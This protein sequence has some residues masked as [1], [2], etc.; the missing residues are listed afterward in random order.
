MAKKGFF[1][2]ITA[3]IIALMSRTGLADLTTALVAYYPFS[4]N[5]ND[6]SGNG[7]HGN[8]NG[9]TLTF[10]RFGNPNSAYSF[11]G[12]D[13]I[14][15][16]DSPQFTLGS[17]PFTLASWAKLSSFGADGG[18]YLMGHS[19]GPGQTDK[20]IF[21]L[22]NSGIIFVATQSG[23][24]WIEFVGATFDL[25][26][27]Y[28][29]AVRRNASELTAFVDG[30][31]IGTASID[32]SIPDPAAP[33]L[34]GTAE[35]DRPNRQFRGQIDDVRIY[36]CALSDN[37]IQTLYDYNPA[38]GATPVANA[39]DDQ[40]V[41]CACQSPG[42]TKV[43]LDGSGSYDS[44]GDTLTYTWTG[45]F[46]ES[47]ASVPNPTVT[48]DCL[49]QYE[50][51]LIVN[52]GQQDSAPDT[53]TITVVD[54]TAPVI[55]CP[56]EITIGTWDP[57][58]IPVEDERIQAFLNG[59]SATDNCDPQPS[60]VDDAP[61]VFQPGETIVTFTATDAS[62]NV[63]T[64]QSTVTV[65]EPVEACLQIVP[66]MIL[67]ESSLPKEILAVIRLYLSTEDNID[68]D[69][70]LML[71]PGDSPYYIE[72]TSQ[73]I[74]FPGRGRRLPTIIYGYFSRDDVMTAISENGLVDF[75][76]F[77]R[78][79]SGRY[80]YGIATVRIISRN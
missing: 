40:T 23:S 6:E 46:A 43:T 66:Q 63:S 28:H 74:I 53:V 30:I 44:D 29:V 27:W 37:E 47:P 26:R 36:V 45:P 10:D 8:I 48:L 67:R 57:G 69:E 4:G 39:G 55:S 68:M 65:V 24:H 11:N 70:P 54:T 50:I 42:G 59:V 51:T 56:D 61:A 20:W 72:A 32:F 75:T 78:F 34:I 14:S 79:T 17:S 13:Y 9:A 3:V 41:E 35:F 7:H 21:W 19:E 58:G 18:Y 77:G 71:F 80:F 60:I 62:G 12:D 5:A 38:P 64:C 73:R 49:G 2:I 25:D 16:P 1:I 15:V 31:P 76:V 33:F 22:G 52:D